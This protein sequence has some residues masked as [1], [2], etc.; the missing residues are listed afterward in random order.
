MPLVV[1]GHEDRQIKFF[2]LKSGNCAFSMSAHLD[3]VSCIDIDPSGMYLAS[4]GKKCSVD[5]FMWASC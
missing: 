1:S 5:C 3:A 4:G 2:D